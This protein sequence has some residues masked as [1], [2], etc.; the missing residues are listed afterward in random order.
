MIK[1]MKRKKAPY[2][3]LN[4][5]PSVMMKR[6]R[7]RKMIKRKKR[8]M[9][10]KTIRKMTRKMTK[11]MRRKMKLRKKKRKMTKKMPKL[12]LNPTTRNTLKRESR[13]LMPSNPKDTRLKWAAAVK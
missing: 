6:K 5:D 8:K 2:S 1:K 3:N 12:L 10:K 11:R 4:K 13:L 9:I 7:R